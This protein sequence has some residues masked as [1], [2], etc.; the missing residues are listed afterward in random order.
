VFV[1]VFLCVCVTI[2][3]RNLL[4]MIAVMATK[5]CKVFLLIFHASHTVFTVWCRIRRI[6]RLR[7]QLQYI[8]SDVN[9]REL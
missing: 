4:L 3:V 9:G 7:H 1:C 6:P 5:S 8:C 2:F